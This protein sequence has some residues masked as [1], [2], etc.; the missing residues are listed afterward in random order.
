M[1]IQFVA[2]WLLASSNAQCAAVSTT[3]RFTA[4]SVTRLAEQT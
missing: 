2:N 3:E 1:N 4:S